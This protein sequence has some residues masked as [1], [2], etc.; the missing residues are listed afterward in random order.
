MSLRVVT[1][2]CKQ[3]NQNTMLVVLEGDSREELVTL[4]ARNAAINTARQFGFPARGISSI[5]HPF[6]I[7]DKGETS[8]ALIMGGKPIKAWRADYVVS[9]GLGL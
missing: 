2:L 6:P 7:D 3:S 1:D 8:D 5:P 9:V 4:E